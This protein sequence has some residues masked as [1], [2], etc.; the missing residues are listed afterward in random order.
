MS[1]VNKAGPF[2]KWGATGCGVGAGIGAFVYVYNGPGFPENPSAEAAKSGGLVGGVLGLM[3]GVLVV[4]AM[5]AI[6]RN[7]NDIRKRAAA[8]HYEPK[9]I[10]ELLEDVL[11]GWDWEAW[12]AVGLLADYRDGELTRQ[13]L[14]SM[15]DRFRNPDVYTRD[16]GAIVRHAVKSILRT[17]CVES[18][19]QL[20]PYAKDFGSRLGVEVRRLKRDLKE[21][22][23]ITS[24]GGA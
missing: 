6:D 3:V 10:P 21:I 20:R 18:V 1:E 7:R 23:R 16:S 11:R 8:E 4:L 24:E 22:N 17:K 13:M 14:A 12:H 19:E 5:I 15:E 9:V 2:L